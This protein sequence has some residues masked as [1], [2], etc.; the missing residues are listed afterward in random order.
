MPSLWEACPLLPM[1]V[2]ATGSPLI[3][4]DCIGLREVVADTPT[5]IIPPRDSQ[6]LAD[7]IRRHMETDLESRFAAY[8]D[9]AL[10]RYDVSQQAVGILE[11]YRELMD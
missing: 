10:R 9:E 11:M 7:A 8:A 4:S 6:A 2:L 5:T 3:A 1:E